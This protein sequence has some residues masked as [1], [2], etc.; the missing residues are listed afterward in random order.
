MR[1]I[2]I[3]TPFRNGSVF[4]ALM[5]TCMMERFATLSIAILENERWAVGSYPLSEGMVI[6]PALRKF[7]GTDDCW[8]PQLCHNSARVWTIL[9]AV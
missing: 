5:L 1:L 4:D 7:K 8:C 3:L 2:Y 9:Y 6:L